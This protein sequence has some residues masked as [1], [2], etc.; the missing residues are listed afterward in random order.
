MN[1][2]LANLPSPAGNELLTWLECAVALLGIA[3]LLKTFLAKIPQPFQVTGETRMATHEELE[4]LRKDFDRFSATI[5]RQHQEL[6]ESL[7][8]ISHQISQAG[9]ERAI[10][11][12]KRLNDVSQSVSDLA[13]Y[14]RGKFEKK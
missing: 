11:I 8:T 2:C 3:V 9:E 4:A 13:G 1:L 14:I 5:T 12:H 6:E 7:E 10:A